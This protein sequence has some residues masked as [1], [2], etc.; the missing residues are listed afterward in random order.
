MLT[1]LKLAID[2]LPTGKCA[3]ALLELREI[4]IESDISPFE[5]NYSG[6]I[7]ALLSYLADL[8][9]PFDRDQRMRILLNVFADMPLGSNVREIENINSTWMR[10]LV[11]KLNGKFMLQLEPF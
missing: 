6:L 11:A 8:V 10:A 7:K 2:K 3:E 1:R 4:L 9:G 5:V